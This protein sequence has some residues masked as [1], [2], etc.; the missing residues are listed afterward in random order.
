M[1]EVVDPGVVP[2]LVSPAFTGG[3]NERT[4]GLHVQGPGAWAYLTT[5]STP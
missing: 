4:R 5:P 3:E 1:C 2:S